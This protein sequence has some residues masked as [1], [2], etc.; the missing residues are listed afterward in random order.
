MLKLKIIV[1][2]LAVAGMV[3]L[4]MGGTYLTASLAV[5]CTAVA[6]PLAGYLTWKYLIPDDHSLVPFVLWVPVAELPALYAFRD[7]GVMNTPLGVTIEPDKVISLG[8]FVALTNAIA[9]LLAVVVP[10]SPKRDDDED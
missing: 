10:R 6:L 2:M 4:L 1:S 8:G 9:I 3:M 5:I 7:L